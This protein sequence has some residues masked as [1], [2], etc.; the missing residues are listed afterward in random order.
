VY[1]ETEEMSLVSIV[2]C[3]VVVFI[4]PHPIKITNKKATNMFF[5]MDLLL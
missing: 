2:S 4:E 5:T 1:P 3:S